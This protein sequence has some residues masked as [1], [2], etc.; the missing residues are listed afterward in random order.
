MF[1][2]EK[3][4]IYKAAVKKIIFFRDLDWAKICSIFVRRVGYALPTSDSAS[5]VI[6]ST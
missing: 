5:A 6:S 1:K 4:S 3:Q 2:F